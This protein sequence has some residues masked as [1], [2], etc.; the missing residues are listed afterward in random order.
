M[1][2]STSFK[3]KVTHPFK[4][5]QEQNLQPD[6]SK[7]NPHNHYTT[8]LCVKYTFIYWFNA[9]NCFHC[10]LRKLLGQT[11]VSTIA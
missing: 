7:S 2:P 8:R 10:Q 1:S 6:N 4:N 11:E 5:G 9:T 3:P